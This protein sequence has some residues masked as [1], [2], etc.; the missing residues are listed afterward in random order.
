[1]ATALETKVAG[2][3]PNA[4]ITI[5]GT[6][7]QVSFNFSMMFEPGEKT[8]I[9]LIY[10]SETEFDYSGDVKRTGTLPDQSS[11]ANTTLTLAQVV[12]LGVHHDLTPKAA[13][14]GTLGWENWSALENQFITVGNGLTATLPRNWDD[15]YRIGAGFHYRVGEPWLVR[16]GVNY[17]SSPTDAED[18]TADLPVDTQ[19][20]LG[21]GFLHD[22]GEKFS[23]GAD[24]T[25]A[26]LGDGEI[27]STGF[28]GDLVGK[29]KTNAY[30]AAAFNLQWRFK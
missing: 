27:D 22:R 8:R 9:G 14:V 30:L 16:V 4:Q 10:V 1:M 19:T 28:V 6:D 7:T 11:Q 13:I 5:D 24:L 15:T 21:A 12:R 20:R 26:D 2:L 18:R 23:W 17:D 25:Y 29:Y 3:G